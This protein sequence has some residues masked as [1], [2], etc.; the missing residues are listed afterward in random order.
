MNRKIKITVGKVDKKIKK[1][2][3]KCLYPNCD[4]PSI[5]SHSQQRGGQLTEICEN[6]K[7][8]ALN[9][10]AYDV[11][12][13]NPDA[14]KLISTPIK[15][16]SIFPGYCQTHDGIVFKP[17]EREELKKGD[18][19]Q[20]AAFF[21][22]TISYEV[23]RKKIVKIWR[24]EFLKG[25]SDVLPDNIREIYELQLKGINKFIETDLP[26]YL[27]A[28]FSQY[29][30]PSID[31]IK[32]KWIVIDKNVLASSCTA[33]S[34]IRDY[35][36]RCYNAYY[37]NP[38]VLFSFNLV[39]AN[40]K[41]H[42]VVSWLTEHDSYSDWIMESMKQELES[43]INYVAICES[44]DICIGPR[45][46]NDTDKLTQEKIFHVMEPELYRGPI[47]ELPKLIRI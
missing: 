4:E 32:T 42:V 18:A 33:F 30:D 41:T 40:G 8:F 1:I 20:A 15:K 26:Y 38:Q 13:G 44:E 31:R 25:C 24:E 12:V 11:L 2:K 37:G 19:L 29:N 36:A 16:A 45:L 22:R 39:P 3:F 34:P 9:P 46:W 6:N 28:A 47:S 7:V 14:L 23:T 21:L 5:G 43:F 10:N 27:D 35:K 17:I